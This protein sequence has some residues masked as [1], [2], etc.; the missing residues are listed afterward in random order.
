MVHNYVIIWQEKEI[1]LNIGISGCKSKSMRV[2]LRQSRDWLA[3]NI[4]QL[5]LECQRWDVRKGRHARAA[6]SRCP[7]VVNTSGA[8][9]NTVD[10]HF[11]FAAATVQNGR[12][13]LQ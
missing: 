12:D 10:N 11:R 7:A 1:E 5:D 6:L 2:M 9:R 8:P 4:Q 3:K 13:W